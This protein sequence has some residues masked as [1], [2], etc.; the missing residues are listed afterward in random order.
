METSTETTYIYI[1]ILYFLFHQS[2]VSSGWSRKM[3]PKIW[4]NQL[5]MY[6]P[7]WT[8]H[9]YYR[10][11]FV[12]IIEPNRREAG[13]RRKQPFPRTSRSS[14]PNVCGL[15]IET[16]L[17]AIAGSVSCRYLR[18]FYFIFFSE[19]SRTWQILRP[20]VSRR[21]IWPVKCV[22]TRRKEWIFYG[23]STVKLSALGWAFQ[24]WCYS[25]TNPEHTVCDVRPGDIHGYLRAEKLTEIFGC[26]NH[27]K[28]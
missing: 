2:Q 13:Q 27:T 26:T 16:K 15:R 3:H 24:W 5:K 25:F 6:A 10:D 19:A 7:F 18:Q 1:Y 22:S 12:Y 20:V 21:N 23:L 11:F 9:W 4:Q 8:K 17:N 14:N 28:T